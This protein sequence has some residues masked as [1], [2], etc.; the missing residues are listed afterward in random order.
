MPVVITE[1]PSIPIPLA[2]P[3]KRWTRYECDQLASTGLL[4]LAELEL[5]E[6][7]LISTMGKKRPHIIVEGGLTMWIAE[8]FGLLFLQVDGTIDVSPEDNPTN[9]PMP[10]FVV[11]NRSFK[12]IRSSHTK[13]ED[14]RLLIEVSDSTVQFDR[15]TKARLYARAGIVEYWIID[16]NSR[17]VIVHRAPDAGIYTSVVAYAENEPI[18]PLAAAHAEFRAV[19]VLPDLE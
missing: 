16:I 19:T 5:I 10:D 3:R 1:A 6:G 11:L 8:V 17:K 9:E 18:A 4:D 15:T 2:P 7:E 13:P 12:E 14:I